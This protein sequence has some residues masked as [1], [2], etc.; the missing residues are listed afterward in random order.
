MGTAPLD[1]DTQIEL[2]KS[3][4]ERHDALVKRWKANETVRSVVRRPSPAQTQGSYEFHYE[5]MKL[6]R[7]G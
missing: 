3:A 4:Q 1:R 6:V 7:C 5:G 2:M